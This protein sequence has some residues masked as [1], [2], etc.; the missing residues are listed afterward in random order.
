MERLTGLKIGTCSWKYPSWQGMVYSADKDINYL[1]EYSRKYAT[2]EV[3]Q[4]FWSL[5]KGG[6]VKLPD[7]DDVRNYRD[8]V[9]KGFRFTVKVPNSIT[10]TH[11]YKKT[12][13]D[14]LEKN[15]YFLS[16]PLFQE[17]LNLLE[18]IH[19]CLG[20][21]IFQFGYLNK[22]MVK[23]QKEFLESMS[24]FV[25]EIPDNHT[26]AI[27][28][29]NQNYL[30]PSY[31][32]M[33][34]SHHLA[35]VFLQGYWM[36]DITTIYDKYHRQISQLDTAIIRLHGSERKGIEK[37]TGDKWDQIVSPK[38][39]EIKKIAAMT[40]SLIQEGLNVFVNVN[41]HYEGSAPKTL[42]RFMVQY[43]EMISYY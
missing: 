3:D 12:K 16:V 37:M 9:P 35:H 23:S 24:K 14:P 6:K 31:F 25:S 13:T 4:W 20:P 1:A 34:N 41:N 30:N 36:P 29:R 10:L 18:P 15:P 33:L 5:F 26:Y 19:D 40:S 39:K 22:Q 38:D 27:E 11:H 32:D 7:P 17:F 43:N 42:D 28:T 2:V 21:L 8:S